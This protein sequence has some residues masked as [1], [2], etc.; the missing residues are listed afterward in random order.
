MR[1][2]DVEGGDEC[3]GQHPVSLVGVAREGVGAESEFGDDLFSRWATSSSG[4]VT[5]SRTSMSAIVSMND[6]VKSMN[7]SFIALAFSVLIVISLRIVPPA[8]SGLAQGRGTE[9]QRLHPRKD[10]EGQEYR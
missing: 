7:M 10:L 3:S 5:H 1:E 8:R 2:A 9:A 4:V 6:I